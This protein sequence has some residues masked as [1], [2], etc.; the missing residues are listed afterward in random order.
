[1]A[2][3]MTEQQQVQILHSGVFVS[4]KRFQC[5]LLLCV[6]LSACSDPFLVTQDNIEEFNRYANTKEGLKRDYLLTE[7]IVLKAPEPGASNWTPIGKDFHI[8]GTSFAG[9]F[10][11]NGHTVTGLTIH[12]TDGTNQESG[13]FGRIDSKAVIQNLGLKDVSIITQNSTV[14]GVVGVNSGTVQ[15]CYSEGEVRGYTVG[16]VVGVNGGT[17]QNCYSMGSVIGAWVGGVVGMNSGNNLVQNSYSIAS[18]TGGQFVGGVVGQ[19]WGGTVKNSYA[20]GSVMGRD[21]N[22]ATVGGVVGWNWGGT[23]ENS[24]ATGAPNGVG[25]RSMVGSVVGENSGDTKVENCV[26]LSPMVATTADTAEKIGRVVGVN[27]EGTLGNNHARDDMRLIYGYAKT[28]S[29]TEAHLAGKD[30]VGT[31]THNTEAF[32]KTTLRWDFSRSW[33]W[34]EGFLPTLRNVGGEQ[35]PTVQAAP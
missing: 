24:Y 17:V 10:D 30:G 21:A 11:G 1:M 13:L 27:S 35:T 32:W 33:E 20:T 9:T 3:G 8:N 15:N 31:S 34:K 7:D 12:A 2:K 4:K 19:N 22:G 25:S 16:G 29:P 28:H 18:V 5:T 23:V 26:A 6:L 14:G